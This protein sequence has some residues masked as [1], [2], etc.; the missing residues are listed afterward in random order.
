MPS[1]YDSFGRIVR[2]PRK[3]LDVARAPDC[4]D[5]AGRGG[6]LPFGNGRSYGD[7]CHNDTG[8]LADFRATNRIVAFNASEGII[9]AE[10]GAMLHDIID[11][12]APY[13]WFLPVT[14]GTRFVTLGG[15]VANDVHGKNHH[16]RGA[17]G[18]HVRAIELRRSGAG[19][20]WL[21]R[22][23]E[24]GMFAATVGG[25]GLTGLIMRVRLKLMK[26]G[27]LDVVETV[28]PFARLSE[29]FDQAEQADASNEYAVAWLDQ[30]GGG[31]ETRGVL[32]T[33]NH[34]E[35][36]NF[37]AGSHRPNLSVPFDLPFNALNPLSLR[38]FNGA[39]YHAKARKAGRE[40]VSGYQGFFYPLDAV[41]NW[42]RLYGPRGLFQHQSALPFATARD[43]IPALLQ[44]SRAAGE[45]SFL[46]VLKR[47]GDM[48]SGGV[49]SFPI[50]GYTLTLDFPNR[51]ARTLKL[52]ETL[53]R[54]T[55]E[56]SGRVN[57]YKDARM[58]P[59]TFTRSFP[60]WR[61]LEARR[62]P[63]ICSDFWRRSAL[64][65]RENGIA[66]NFSDRLE[67]ILT[68]MT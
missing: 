31:G 44:A 45:A 47:F 35:N 14:P 46:T 3:A 12:V 5:G 55:I 37:D 48:R 18:C 64:N 32:L 20:V 11:H 54:I 58:S 65:V 29:Y 23:E 61:D 66:D 56:A 8:A 15:A 51:G 57:P 7:S 53:D 6:L 19:P 25:M 43:A 67:P 52:L 60:Q 1:S 9:E 28:T 30:L 21:D 39:F 26:V 22:D 2:R 63:N 68:A 24:T 40:L 34:A 16:R 38:L 36:G 17:F 4:I 33:A 42:N 41:R 27:S 13:G 49:M 62:D 50:P 59:R 10:A